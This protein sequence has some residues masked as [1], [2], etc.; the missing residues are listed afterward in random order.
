MS[1]E[2][3]GNYYSIETAE[4]LPEEAP[5]VQTHSS[6]IETLDLWDMPV[7]LLFLFGLLAGEMG[8][9]QEI[10]YPLMDLPASPEMRL[11][12]TNSQRFPRTL[13]RPLGPWGCI[14]LPLLLLLCMCQ[15]V[16]GAQLQRVNLIIRGLAGMPEYEEAFSDWTSKLELMLS[17]QPDTRVEVLDGSTQKR[18]EILG[19]V[20]EVLSLLPPQGELWVFLVGHG[21]YDGRGYRFNIAGPDITGDDLAKLLDR[22]EEG[23][24]FLI[25]G[26]SAS[27]ILIPKLSG[28]NRVIVTATKNQFE[29]QPPLFL[30]FL[31]EA[32]T[33]SEADRDKNGKVSLLEAFLFSRRRV[34]DWFQEK[35][36]LQTEHALL[37]DSSRIR[38]GGDKKDVLRSGSRWHRTAGRYRLSF[39]TSGKKFWLRPTPEC[40]L[41]EEAS[42]SAR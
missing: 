24:T 42:W 32:S 20:S 15:P 21:S 37:D 6:V 34:E 26:T 39:R 2:T 23:R 33:T 25:A 8:A 22:G 29:R 10:R 41:S 12:H 7:N 3:G 40:W 38:L 4:N 13:E 14:V 19:T 30:S 1:E 16:E 28:K 36:R 31:V 35:G 9:A 17:A 18:E 5:Y 11:D 27:G